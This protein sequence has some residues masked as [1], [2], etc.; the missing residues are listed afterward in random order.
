MTRSATWDAASAQPSDVTALIWKIAENGA[1]AGMI[2]AS[3]VAVWFLVLDVLTRGL[4][5]FTPSLLGSIIF[6]GAAPE[7]V[8]G[9]D[10]AAIFAYTG[11]HGVLFLGAGTVLAWMFSQFERNPQVGMVLLLLFVTFEAILWGVGVSMIPA[12]AG[13]VGAW[14]ILVANVASATAMFVFLVRRH[15]RATERL[16]QAWNQ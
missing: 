9:L 3:V 8:S 2:G 12:L 13:A 15:P 4:P 1:L 7:Q 16:R 5:F 6:A 10:G 11:L 14:A